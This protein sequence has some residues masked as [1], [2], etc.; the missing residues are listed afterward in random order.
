MHRKDT[1]LN[2][3]LLVGVSSAIAFSTLAGCGANKHIR[4][5]DLKGTWFSQDVSFKQTITFNDDETYTTEAF[6][7]D[8][9]YQIN[10][11]TGEVKLVTPERNVITLYPEKVN[12]TWELTYTGKEFTTVVFS[13]DEPQYE[14]GA[15]VDE[16]PY[17]YIDSDR[18]RYIMGSVAQ[19]LETG[20]WV[21]DNG[22]EVK[23]SKDSCQIGNELP[24]E[25]ELQSADSPENGVF[26]FT[27]SGETGTY[28]GRLVI[29]CDD[30]DA[31]DVKGYSLSLTLNGETLFEAYSS[32][33]IE[34]EQID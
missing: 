4:M 14:T 32:G 13:M 10:K 33:I 17:I 7:E 34:V 16:N 6:I 26:T 23:I 20:H 15:T 18:S 21:N 24:I 31:Y 22:E 3:A 25:Y 29:D 28:L 1:F 2:K 9:T 30:W 27:C 8:G 5:D 11:Q 12:D 19:Y